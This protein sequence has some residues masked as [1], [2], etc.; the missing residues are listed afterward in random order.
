M[1]VHVITMLKVPVTV[2]D[3]VDVIVVRDL[4]AV[5]VLGVHGR[6]PDVNLLLGMAF[7]VVKMVDVIAVN[8]RL[9][10]VSRKVLVV[11]R[12][13]VA[14]SGH[15]FPPGADSA[16]LTIGTRREFATRADVLAA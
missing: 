11:A 16:D 8:H 4:L 12:F 5:V 13:G 15:G 14:V 3:V 10:A 6:V 2:M 7:A 9:V 1:L